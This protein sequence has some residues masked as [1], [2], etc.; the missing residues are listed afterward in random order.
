MSAEEPLVIDIGD[1]F[2][3]AIGL[4]PNLDNLKFVNECS[5][6]RVLADKMLGQVFYTLVENSLRHGQ[7]VTEIRLHYRKENSQ[8]AIMYEDNGVGINS[9]DKTRLFTEGFSTGGSTGLGLFLSKKI[10]DV[11]GWK[12]HERG[13]PGTGVLFEFTMPEI[14]KERLVQTNEKKLCN[15]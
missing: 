8:I 15:Q 10:L 11:Y 13:T 9:E 3:Q 6:L 4:I 7:K 5:G 14:A 12:I 1:C 2:K